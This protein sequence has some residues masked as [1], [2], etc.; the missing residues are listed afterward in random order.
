MTVCIDVDESIFNHVKMSVGLYKWVLLYA[1]I[2]Y[3]V[4]AFINTHN[5]S[6]ILAFKRMHIYT[7]KRINVATQPCCFI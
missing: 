2:S 6:P 7:F 3:D 5:Q 4:I 1:Y